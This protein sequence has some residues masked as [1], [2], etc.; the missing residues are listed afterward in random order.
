MTWHSH[1]TPKGTFRLEVES[2]HG[3]A[4][5]SLYCDEA[6]LG[7]FFSGE[8]LARSLAADEFEA[9]LGFKTS[10]LGIPSDAN[11]WTTRIDLDLTGL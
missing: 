3:S 1:W 9:T 7:I 4:V 10:N 6:F 5:I 8:T 11:E 2:R